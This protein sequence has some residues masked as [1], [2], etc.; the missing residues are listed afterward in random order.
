MNL[1]DLK[2]QLRE[3]FQSITGR[4]A[5]SP[6]WN[7]LVEKYSDLPP[8][9]Q[10]AALAGAAFVSTLILLF[11]PSCIFMSS[12]TNLQDFEDKKQSMRELFRVHREVSVLPPAPMPLTPG[13]LENRARG[14]LNSAGLQPDQLGGVT[15]FDNK[16]RSSAWIPKALEQR[17]VAVTVKKLNLQQV[18]DLGNRL[19]RLQQTAMLTGL[20]VR[21]QAEDPHYFDVVYKIVAFSLPPEPLSKSGKK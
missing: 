5:E 8:Q 9:G 1:D 19:Q 11:V 16:T 17:G 21:A 4:I 15:D 20:E 12:S 10:K 6:A 13:E 2:E 3:S 18:V 7:Q 14:E